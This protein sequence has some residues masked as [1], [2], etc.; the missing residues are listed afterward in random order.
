VVVEINTEITTV[1]MT[2]I[3]SESKQKFN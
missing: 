1:I 3:F 2:N